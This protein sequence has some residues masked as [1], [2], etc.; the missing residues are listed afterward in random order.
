MKMGA[1][2]R[3]GGILRYTH[4]IFFLQPE[5][6]AA[7]PP[8]SYLLHLELDGG[9]HGVDLAL[10]VVPGVHEGGELTG[11]GQ[12]GAQQTR[13]LR[14]NRRN[15]SNDKKRRISREPKV[16]CVVKLLHHAGTDSQ[17][18]LKSFIVLVPVVNCF[19]KICDIGPNS[20]LF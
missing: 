2:T 7:T 18:V 20:Q 19:V 3:A 10:E 15:I 12:T 16:N 4:A 8:P 5:R 14:E 17:A 6:F 1:R 13:D 9:A 11:L